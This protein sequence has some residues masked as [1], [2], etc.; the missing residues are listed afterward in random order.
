MSEQ[1]VSV[2]IVSRGRPDALHRCL[3]GVS[4]LQYTARTLDAQGGAHGVEIDPLQA[5]VLVPPQGRAIKIEGT[6]MTFRRN[7]LVG[8]GRFDPAF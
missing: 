4:Q 3:T 7:V 8:I 2:I 5:T 1:T 6:N